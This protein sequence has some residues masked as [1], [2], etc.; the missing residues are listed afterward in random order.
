MEAAEELLSTFKTQMIPHFPFIVIYP[1]EN[2]QHLRRE[3][4]FLFLAIL[5]TASFAD[6]P[7]QR[8]LGN[9]TKKFIAS[10]MVL[11]GEVSLELLQG[12]LVF[13]AW[14]ALSPTLY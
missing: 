12:L 8:L 14:W 7:L 10:H 9:E 11:N 3:K 6:M 2:A 13:L 5:S 1:H 4:P